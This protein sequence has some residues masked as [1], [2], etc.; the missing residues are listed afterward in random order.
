MAALGSWNNQKCIL[1]FFAA[2]SYQWC[3]IRGPEPGRA[4][5]SVLL[6]RQHIWIDRCALLDPMRSERKAKCKKF[7]KIE[8][9]RVCSEFDLLN[10]RR[11]EPAMVMVMDACLNATVYFG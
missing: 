1:G 11:K 3:K 5:R 9:T 7:Q 10:A 2:T 8:A 4:L 6:I